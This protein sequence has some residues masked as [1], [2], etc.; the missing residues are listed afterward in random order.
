M[1]YQIDVDVGIRIL[2]ADESVAD[3]D[4]RSSDPLP[5]TGVYLSLGMFLD[6]MGLVLITIP[7][8]RPA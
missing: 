5:L 8:F 2:I 7:T 3:G 4:V 6:Q 1:H